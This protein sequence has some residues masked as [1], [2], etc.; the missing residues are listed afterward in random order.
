MVGDTVEQRAGQALGPECFRPLV[1]G[2]IAGAQGRAALVALRDQLEQQFRTGLRER[3]EA[4][5]VTTEELLGAHRLMETSQTPTVA[6]LHHLSDQK[7][8]ERSRGTE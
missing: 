1:N 3:H 4:Q 5:L 8:E 7:P 2:Q 6:R